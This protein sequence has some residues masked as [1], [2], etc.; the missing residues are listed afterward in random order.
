MKSYD[1]NKSYSLLIVK[2]V[3]IKEYFNNTDEIEY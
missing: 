2:A 1:E 3:E